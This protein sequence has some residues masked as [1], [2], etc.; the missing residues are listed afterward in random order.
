MDTERPHCLVIGVGP[1]TGL[2]CVRRFVD[3]GY[4]VSMIARH[5]GRLESWAKEIPHTV[6]YPTDLTELP[7][8]RAVLERIKIEQGRP[9]VIIYNASLATLGHYSELDVADFE[10]NFRAN[11]TGLLITAQVFGPGMVEAGG[12]SIIITGNTGARRGIPHFAGFAPTKASQMILGESLARELGPR[13]VHV[14]YVMIDAMI[15]MPMVR[16]R[17]PDKPAESLAQ[18]EDIAGEVFHIAHQPRSTWS[19]LHEIRPFGEKW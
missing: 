12:G 19:Y 14:A 9:E 2:A 4:K 17:M 8:S 11:T 5:E 7:G 10:R 15:D 16:K 13:N 1:G 3:E 18:P 6:G